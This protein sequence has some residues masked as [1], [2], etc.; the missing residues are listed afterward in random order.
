[1]LDALNDVERAT[2]HNAA[3]ER[4]LLIKKM[5]NGNQSYPLRG[6]GIVVRRMVVGNIE[7]TDKTKE[8]VAAVAAATFFAEEQK[9]LATSVKEE[10]V[11][12]AD[13]P[14][15]R[16]PLEQ[17]LLRRKIT[18]KKTDVSRIELSPELTEIIGSLG[19]Q[20]IGSVVERINKKKE[21]N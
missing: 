21:G 11:S 9:I 7:P 1:M 8:A 20:L 15:V 16:D 5:R 4:S 2:L 17:A 19:G 12:Y 14:G 3:Q 13:I 18:Q 6:L 10:A